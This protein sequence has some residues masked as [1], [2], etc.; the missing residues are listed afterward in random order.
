MSKD[1]AEIFELDQRKKKYREAQIKKAIAEIDAKIAEEW[2]IVEGY[3]RARLEQ[4]VTTVDY[5]VSVGKT[6]PTFRRL[7]KEYGVK[8][9][10]FIGGKS[11]QRVKRKTRGK[12]LTAIL[13]EKCDCVTCRVVKPVLGRE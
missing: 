7:L 4:M 12:L 9:K 1:I 13:A 10:W 2:P 6:D 11:W 3:I 8:Q 5:A